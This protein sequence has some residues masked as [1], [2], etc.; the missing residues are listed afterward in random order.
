[1]ALQ[2]RLPSVPGGRFLC[3]CSLLPEIRPRTGSWGL[4]CLGLLVGRGNRGG[5]GHRRTCIINLC[6]S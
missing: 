2:A 1:M 6:S 3:S 4:L 5:V